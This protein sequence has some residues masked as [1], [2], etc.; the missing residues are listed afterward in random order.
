MDVA[1]SGS[2]AFFEDGFCD[3][4]K[5]PLTLSGIVSSPR[6]KFVT[7]AMRS[8]P[9]EPDDRSSPRKA[10]FFTFPVMG[11]SYLCPFLLGRHR[12]ARKDWHRVNALLAGHF[13]DV[14]RPE[15][16]FA[17]DYL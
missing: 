2:G 7:W 8:S 3:S 10:T 6:T 9:S 13:S 12:M 11:P 15:L 5:S 16:P 17:D 4:D 1:S 14:L